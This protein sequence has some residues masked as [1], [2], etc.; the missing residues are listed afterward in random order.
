VV[1][2]HVN[3]VQMFL[4]RIRPELDALQAFKAHTGDVLALNFAK[5]CSLEDKLLSYYDNEDLLAN[6]SAGEKERLLGKVTIAKGVGYDKWRLETGK[7][8]QKFS[9]EIQV[10]IVHQQLDGI[11]NLTGFWQTGQYEKANTQL[12]TT[13][14]SL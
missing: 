11:V 14:F 7:S 12:P 5:C 1:N 10:N 13:P 8:D 3:T 2:V 4:Q 9:H 6:L